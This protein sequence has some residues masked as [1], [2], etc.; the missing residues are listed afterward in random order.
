MP[1]DSQSTQTKIMKKKIYKV[2]RQVNPLKGYADWDASPWKAIL[3]RRIG[4]YMG[5][6]PGHFPIAEV[7]IAYDDMAIH[8][9]F[10]VQDRFV[11]AV[12]PEDQGKVWEDSCVEF[13]FT[14]GSDLSTGYFNLEMNCGGTMLFHFHPGTG[15][16]KIVIPKRECTKIWRM[17]SLPTI[18]DPEIHEPVTWTLAYEL[19]LAVFKK[20]CRVVMP[21]PRATWRANFYKCADKTSH[22]HWLTWSPVDFAKPNFHLPRYFGILEFQ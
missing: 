9:M 16:E 5:N 1:A 8:V 10:R 15:K 17:H 3:P 4:N 2:A 18:V 11:R 19:P 12:A 22:P 6:Q 20:Y 13:F 21:G 7:K 14:P